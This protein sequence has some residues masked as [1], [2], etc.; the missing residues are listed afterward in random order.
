TVITCDGENKDAR[1]LLAKAL[2][3]SKSDI[4]RHAVRACLEVNVNEKEFSRLIKLAKGDT[5]L[6]VRAVSCHAATTLA[7][8]YRNDEAFT[9]DPDEIALYA[10]KRKKILGLTKKLKAALESVMARDREA[11]LREFAKLCLEALNSQEFIDLDG[12]L[13]E[14]FSDDELTSDES[15]DKRKRRGGGGRR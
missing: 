5:D 10:K 6:K 3:A 15:S 13:D 14:L 9:V 11:K 4:R 2:K 12:D 1:K 7:V 8:R